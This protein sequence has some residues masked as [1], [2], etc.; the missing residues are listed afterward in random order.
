MKSLVESCRS[1]LRHHLQLNERLNQLI[2]V[3]VRKMIQY[4]TTRKSLYFPFPRR[5]T[6]FLSWTIILKGG[7][8]R[9]KLL[10]KKKGSI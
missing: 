7:K 4:N 5:I 2:T 6:V 10:F 3:G 1:E 8:F 9:E